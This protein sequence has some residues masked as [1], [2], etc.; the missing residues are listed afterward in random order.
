MMHPSYMSHAIRLA[1]KGWYTARPNPR[2]GCVIVNHG[3]IVGEGFHRKAGEPHAE[4]HA[5]AATGDAAKHAVVYV[6]L[7]PCA[8]HGR[9]PPCAD[10]LVKAGVSCAVIGMTDPNPQVSGLGMQRLRDAG[11][12]VIGDVLR[13][14]AEALNRGFIKRMQTGLPYVR[15]KTAISLDGRTALATG[16]SRWITGSQ[17]RA[18]VH[19][20]RAESGAI[21]TGMGTVSMDDPSLT[22]RTDEYHSLKMELPEG[23]RQPLRVVCDSKG[24][25]SPDARILGSD[26]LIVTTEQNANT[27]SLQ[28]AGV[29]VLVM[30]PERQQVPLKA[31]LME[32]GR[33][34]INDVMVEAGAGLTGA[35]LAAKLVD[36]LVIYMAPHLMGDTARGMASMPGINNMA[37]R[38]SLQIDDIR[39]IGK[40]WRIT[41]RPAD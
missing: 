1:K 32:L 21:L 39:A 20:L 16:E 19:R 18:D 36:E 3:D 10:T 41:A 5:L 12:D 27:D 9:T 30:E 13:A 29:E 23:V 28:Q 37:D 33:R 31:L 22:F 4:A 15:I 24:Q 7:E 38:L 8:H 34:E 25:L 40:D 2:V 11:I 14:D 6:T 17:A 35:L 26:A